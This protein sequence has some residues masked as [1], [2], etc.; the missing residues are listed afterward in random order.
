VKY[1]K[2]TVTI[3]CHTYTWKGFALDEESAFLRGVPSWLFAKMGECT[4]EDDL[5]YEV[6][7][8]TPEDEAREEAF[9]DDI[10]YSYI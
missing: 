7:E 10:G 6:V 3:R 1:Y 9:S 4:I 8:W 5:R 2:V